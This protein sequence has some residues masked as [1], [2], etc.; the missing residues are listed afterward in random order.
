MPAFILN[1]CVIFLFLVT[2]YSVLLA[3]NFIPHHHAEEVAH[4]H[5]NHGHSHDE[6]GQ[7]HKDAGDAFQH[8]GHIDGAEVQY[9]PVLSQKY[10]THKQADQKV[11]LNVLVAFITHFEKPR[12]IIHRPREE[13]PVLPGPLAYWFPLKAQLKE[14]LTGEV[15]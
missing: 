13:G 8:F 11:L 9:V 5:D 6:E 10:S 1:R 12:L 3:H 4:H 14:S 2:A 7:G 15:V